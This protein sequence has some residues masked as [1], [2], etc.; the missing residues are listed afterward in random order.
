MAFSHLPSCIRQRMNSCNLEAG[1]NL[2]R[3]RILSYNN[4]QSLVAY[5]DASQYKRIITL[6]NGSEN[7]TN[8]RIG[9][10]GFPSP[11]IGHFFYSLNLELSS[12]I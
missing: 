7:K 3:K 5:Q 4:E 8:S 10:H 6:G 2:I 12:C 1:Y 11:S 9:H